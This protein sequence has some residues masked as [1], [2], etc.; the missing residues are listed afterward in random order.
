M[1]MEGQQSCDKFYEELGDSMFLK[2]VDV[3]D[4]VALM[5]FFWFDL[6]TSLVLLDLSTT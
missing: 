3:P 1:Q 6:R 2:G 5:L 4:C